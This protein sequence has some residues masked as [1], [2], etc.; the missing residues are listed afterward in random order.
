MDLNGVYNV[1]QTFL[2]IP[3]I[4]KF[5]YFNLLSVKNPFLCNEAQKMFNTENFTFLQ[6]LLWNIFS[7]FMHYNKIGP[8]KFALK[9]IFSIRVY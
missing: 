7:F 5:I 6:R 9:S 4:M 3:L 8:V 2:L 1:P